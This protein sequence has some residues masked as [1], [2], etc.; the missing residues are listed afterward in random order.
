MRKA[1][2]KIIQTT[3]LGTLVLGLSFAP[4]QAGK[5]TAEA[6]QWLQQ[7]IRSYDREDYGAAKT[8]LQMAL[9]LEPNFAKPT[10]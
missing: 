2:Y 9:Q 4:V 5:N 3:F 7:G 8:S 6:T 1:V 10:F